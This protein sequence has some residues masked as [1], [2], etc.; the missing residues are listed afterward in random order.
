MSKRPFSARRRGLV[1]VALSVLAACS[2][3]DGDHISETRIPLAQLRGEKITFEMCG[4]KISLR[5]ASVAA[6]RTNDGEGVVSGPIY[7]V[8]AY[9]NP[10]DLEAWAGLSGEGAVNF[11]CRSESAAHEFSYGTS[12]R[13]FIRKT[14]LPDLGL[15]LLEANTSRDSSIFHGFYRSITADQNDVLFEMQ[16]HSDA[17]EKTPFNCEI[18]GGISRYRFT[19]Y[20][21][22]SGPDVLQNWRQFKKYYETFITTEGST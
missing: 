7:S 8:S 13:K 12:I 18:R 3:P 19:V 21:S 5:R 1:L 11:S 10:D 4:Q 15:E 16:C 9:L 20:M 22:I 14:K 6:L 2:A 17:P